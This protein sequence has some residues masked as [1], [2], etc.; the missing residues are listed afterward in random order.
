MVARSC[1]KRPRRDRHRKAF[2]HEISQAV[3]NPSIQRG[4]SS[5]TSL[6]CVVLTLLSL[7]AMS[8]ALVVPDAWFAAV[9]IASLAIVATPWLLQERLDW[10][11]PWA[12]IILSVFLGSTCTGILVSL[13]WP[14]AEAIEATFRMGEEPGYFVKPCLIFLAGLAALT[15]GYFSR[16]ATVTKK[17]NPARPSNPSGLN[18]ALLYPVLFCL[19][20]ISLWATKEWVKNT[21]GIG[22]ALSAKRTLVVDMQKDFN[23]HG[24]LLELVKFSQ[25][26]FFI[27]LGHLAYQKRMPRPGE[28]ALLLALFGVAAVVPFL[29]SRRQPIVWLFLGALVILQRSPRRFTMVH[30]GAVLACALVAFQFMTMIRG[31]EVVSD[32]VD[33]RF[34]VGKVAQTV[35]LNQNMADLTK[36]SHV[37]NEVGGAL[38]QK[39]GETFL[40]WFLTPV[41]RSVWPEKPI[42]QQYCLEVGADVYGMKVSGIPPGLIAEMYWNFR[43]PGVLIGAALF[44][45]FLRWLSDTFGIGRD[46]SLIALLIHTVGP[47]RMGFDAVG[48]SLGYGFFVSSLNVAVML[49]LLH[50]LREP[51]QTRPVAAVR[52]MRTPAPAVGPQP[53]CSAIA[54]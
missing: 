50:V 29:G 48:H 34:D 23:Q 36:T 3:P 53:R 33:K 51:R 42:I 24:P 45:W 40:L 28:V 10:T 26:G 47:M 7:G 16:G 49:T 30:C 19:L 32:A 22:G 21:G 5:V 44:G 46:A 52:G 18:R 2:P 13:R 6:L 35:V 17:P 12:M 9:G 14:D 20:A 43:L 11:G 41:P 39:N 15:F 8:I 38:E 1:V 4:S 37:I 25:F 31:Q 54:G 27:L